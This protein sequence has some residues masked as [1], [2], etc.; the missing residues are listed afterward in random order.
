MIFEKILNDL[1]VLFIKEDSNKKYIGE[2]NKVLAML[3]DKESQ[4]KVQLENEKNEKKRRN[5][6]LMLKVISK[7]QKKGEK[8]IQEKVRSSQSPEKHS[9]INKPELSPRIL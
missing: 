5:I 4:L 1:K 6:N 7:H 8:L 3:K 2:M 9:I